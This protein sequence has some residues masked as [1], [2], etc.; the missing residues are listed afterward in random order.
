[1]EG[2]CSK[3]AD[4]FSVGGSYNKAADD[5]S[6][7]GLYREAESLYARA[8]VIRAEVLGEE[9]PDVADSLNNLAVLY[10]VQGL[11]GK[12]EPLYERA[13]EIWQ[14][15]FGESHIRVAYALDNLASLYLDQGLYGKAEPLYERALVIRKQVLGEGHPDVADSLR[16]L[17]RLRLGQ[18]RLTDAVPLFTQALVISEGRLRRE[19]LDFSESRLAGFLRFLDED[20]QG[21]HA[22]LR[23]HLGS[24]DVRR[25]AFTSALLF[26]GRSIEEASD[27]SR[28]ILRSMGPDDRATFEH[29][30]ELRT[31]RARL[32]LDGPGE[33]APA[34]YQQRLR[35]LE[36]NAETLEADLAKR[37]APL[38][39]R[40]A[41]PPADDILQRVAAAL[42]PG[43]ALVEFVVY[44]DTPPVPES[45]TPRSKLPA[46]L[47][48]Q[49]LLLFPD[50]RTGA[51]DLG[52]A[53]VV[54]DAIS[55]FRDA[56]ASRDVRVQAAAQK[57]YR[58]AFEPLL[59][60]LASTRKVFVS[61]DG[62]LSL[63]PFAA[64]HD[65]QRFLVD[66][67]DFTY[68]TSGR[69]ILTSSGDI[70]I[71]TSAVILADPDYGAS[72]PA[73]GGGTTPP[74]VEQS[75]APIPGSR[76]EA[77]AIQRLLP[78]AQ[79]LLGP[80]ATKVRLFSL[81]A[82]G[83]LHVATHG[84]FSEDAVV[85][86]GGRGLGS[87]GGIR[88]PPPSDPLLRS[89]L[90]L[91]GAGLSRNNKPGDSFVT[92]L[93]LAG[94][95]LWGTQLVVLSACDTG[96]GDVRRGQGVHGLRR[97]FLAAG[98]QT[99]VVSLW[100]VNDEVTRGLMERYYRNLIAGQ[101]RVAALRES[102]RAV[103]EKHPHPYFWAPFIA[104]G[105]DA[106]LHPHASSNR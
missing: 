45:E 99:L 85:P 24:A 1:M 106:P 29:L 54:D 58:R 33:L 95:D 61:P 103:R 105:L 84:K 100:N 62:Q 69:D 64:L 22:L 35:R 40:R 2:L 71:S 49:A 63:V 28:T 42:P 43:S 101:G 46:T 23:A 8:R 17:G 89:G 87:P 14:K 93:E 79:L 82:P 3:V 10:A 80:A 97:S 67:F 11:Y 55:R 36:E 73:Q 66:T 88:I 50:G 77:E 4:V 16:N 60:L 81:T 47:R 52:P 98:A 92:A 21:L 48:Y 76:Q 90:V 9:H 19:A 32:S 41:R 38:R 78:H 74:Y 75:W 86:P 12:A 30:R 26:K 94:L 57:L 56:L 31:Q 13:L 68:V 96:R 72:P 91:A 34:E 20:G 59:P 44:T 5:A 18:R 39:A 25:L 70:S 15:A 104:V 27:I 83:I 37:S 65:G 6:A 102:M 53:N 51:V 7:E